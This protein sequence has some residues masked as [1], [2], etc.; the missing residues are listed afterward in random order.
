M[1]ASIVRHGAAAGL[2][3]AAVMFLPFLLFGRPS[4]EYLRLGEIIGYSAMVL[5][6]S[7]VWFAMRSRRA[8]NGSLGFSEGL[9]IGAGVSL[10]A[11]LLFGLATWAFYAYS[12]DALPEEIYA[13]YQDQIHQSG[14]DAASIAARLAELERMRPMFFDKTL[15]AG[16]MAAT[17][18]VIGLV[19][20]VISAA[21]LRRVPRTGPEPA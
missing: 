12:G 2:F 20:S 7:A 4:P 21:A 8:L 1:L 10:V 19:L 9:G 17:V 3:I 13:F 14:A 16:I 11:A 18:F 6:L 5:A 15:Q